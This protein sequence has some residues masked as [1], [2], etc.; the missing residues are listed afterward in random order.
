MCDFLQRG[1][2]IAPSRFDAD[3]EQGQSGVVRHG[4]GA[5]GGAMRKIWI[6]AA[7]MAAFLAAFQAAAWPLK[8]LSCYT[9]DDGLTHCT[10]LY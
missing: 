6:G 10:L 5:K 7:A 9:F 2:G 3:G 8:A 4:V 1:I